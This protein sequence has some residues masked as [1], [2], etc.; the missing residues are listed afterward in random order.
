[1]HRS[2]D[3]YCEHCRLPLRYHS[4]T[5]KNYAGLLCPRCVQS[6]SYLYFTA[7]NKIIFPF[8]W[9]TAYIFLIYEKQAMIRLWMEFTVT[10]YVVYDTQHKAKTLECRSSF[11]RW[12]SR[13]SCSVSLR[14][15]VQM[16]ATKMKT[17]LLKYMASTILTESLLSWITLRCVYPNNW[18]QADLATL[19]GLLK[20]Q[21]KLTQIR[22]KEFKM[23]P[24]P[25][26]W[27][28]GH[29]YW[30]FVNHTLYRFSFFFRHL[31]Y[32]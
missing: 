21:N 26:T 29:L 11:H 10:L 15:K 8:I 2:L 17:G 20:T 16:N 9:A 14:V 31:E 25:Y 19:C 3:F 6:Q 5:N 32:T 4:I 22:R 23:N 18:S 12:P 24:I 30:L 27:C 13:L 7:E 28:C 1:M